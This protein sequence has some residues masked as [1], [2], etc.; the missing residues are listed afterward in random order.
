MTYALAEVNIARMLAPLDSPVMAGFVAGLDPLNALAERSPGFIWRLKTDDGNATALRPYEDD[1][2]IVNL[3]MWTDI[4]ALFQYT[5]ASDHVDVFRQRSEWF[6]RM[7][8]PYMTMWYVDVDHRPTPAEARER[9]EYLQAHGPTPHA[10][11]F[12][13][14]FSVE[15]LLKT[16]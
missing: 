7:T 16:T 13:K 4:D 1:Y 10:F 11:T 2:I 3:T 9:L 14:R 8:L 15:D 5:Y 6:E 12:K